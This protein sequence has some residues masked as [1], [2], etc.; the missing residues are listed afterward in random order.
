MQEIVSYCAVCL[1]PERVKTLE[2]ERRRI[3]EAQ[4]KKYEEEAAKFAAEKKKAKH[5]KNLQRKDKDKFNAD[6]HDHFKQEFNPLMGGSSGGKYV[7]VHVCTRQ[8]YPAVENVYI[9]VA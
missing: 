8:S 9:G 4:Q 7:K 1:G 5:A 6:D 3:R 2:K